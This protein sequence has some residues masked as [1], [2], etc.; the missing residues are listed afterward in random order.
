MLVVMGDVSG[1]SD[2]SKIGYVIDIG[3]GLWACGGGGSV[4]FATQMGV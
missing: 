4:T 1:H 2:C 3:S